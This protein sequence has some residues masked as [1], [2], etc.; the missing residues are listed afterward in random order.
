MTL[1]AI[2]KRLTLFSEYLRYLLNEKYQYH[3]EL[4]TTALRGTPEYIMAMY[5]AT[6]FMF[7][8]SSEKKQIYSFDQWLENNG[9]GELVG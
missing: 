3:L 1:T 7:F 9:Y 8:G 4:D 2:D 5:M 6:G